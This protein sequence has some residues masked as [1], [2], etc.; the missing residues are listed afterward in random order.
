MAAESSF[1][2][3]LTSIAGGASQTRGREYA[4]A[5][6]VSNVRRRGGRVRAIVHGT[7]DYAV[8]LDAQGGEC[9]CPYAMDGNICKHMEA[10]ALVAAQ[11]DG[12]NDGGGRQRLSSYLNSLSQGE[13]VD[14][15]LDAAAHDETLEKRLLLAA[16][17]AKG[18]L[19]ALRMQVDAV[20]GGRGMLYY[21]DAIDYANEGADLVAALDRASAGATDAGVIPIIEH[22]LD[23]VAEA[24][25][26]ADDSAGSIGAWPTTCW[27]CTPPR[28]RRPAP[29]RS[30]WP[31]G[32][33]GSRSTSRTW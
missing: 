13:L 32:W 4:A 17:E 29:T 33:S 7:H 10:V 28:A 6:L 23:Q 8:T 26:E 21:R 18:D 15:L 16:A 12:G 27:P 20:L 31:G 30:S 1:I 14:V 11:L 5:G 25:A 19:Q 9:D 22:A 3:Q 2:D 24:L